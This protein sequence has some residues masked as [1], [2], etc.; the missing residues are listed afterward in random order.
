V[1]PPSDQTSNAPNFNYQGSIAYFNPKIKRSKAAA[2][3]LAELFA[4]AVAKPLPRFLTQASNGAMITIIVG[5]TFHG[6]IATPPP[7]VTPK[8]EPPA[9]TYNPDASL[10]LIKSARRRVPFRLEYPTKIEQS[11]IPDPEV[12]IR[13][14]RLDKKH[15]A[16]RLTFRTGSRGY[17]GI[18]MQDWEGA[19]VLS[20]RNFR[21]FIGKR[22]FDLYYSGAHLHMVVL[23]E[24]KATYWVTNTLD[25]ALSN[26]TMLAIARSLRPLKGKVGRAA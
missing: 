16:V 12:P 20:E 8:R 19:P 1:L 7:H 5:H 10:P 26:D 15:K 14:Y 17:W 21:R 23:R 18:Q 25:D 3:R 24:N 22:E 9:V 2:K 11:S 6:R 13:V 4:P